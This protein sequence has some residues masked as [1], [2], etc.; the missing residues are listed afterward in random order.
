MFDVPQMQNNL[1]GHWVEA[2][3]C[4]LLGDGWKHTGADWAAW[5]IES[6][7]GLRVEVKQSARRQSWGESTSSPRFS[8]QAARGH[9][10]D[11]KAY[12]PNLT[13]SRL[14]DIY[15]F[16]WHDGEDQRVVS[17]WEFYVVEAGR[18]PEGRKTIGLDAIR[19]LVNPV[20]ADQLLNEIRSLVG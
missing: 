10:P 6:D 7:D 4:E 19:R 18:L 9:Y 1:R 14:A 20:Q 5:D 12:L 3:V 15:V 13:G 17:Q 11:G 2:M 16:A 8:I